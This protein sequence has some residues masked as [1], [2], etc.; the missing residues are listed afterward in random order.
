[1]SDKYPDYDRADKYR[2]E[3]MYKKEMDQQTGDW[4]TPFTKHFSIKKRIGMFIE[5][6]K[7]V[8]NPLILVPRFQH[9]VEDIQ[10][11]VTEI[12]ISHM[13][14]EQS[15]YGDIHKQAVAE[16]VSGKYT[17]LPTFS[18]TKKTMKTKDELKKEID[19]LKNVRLG[20][21]TEI[22]LMNSKNRNAQIKRDRVTS[23][24]DGLEWMLNESKE[25]DHE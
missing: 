21:S 23:K 18:I 9:L 3:N 25:T 2:H 5:D 14:Q 22:E 11:E 17:Y 4:M 15:W 6:I 24:I 19:E 7:N 1:M 20:I 16:A 8:I 12:D 10:R 13:K